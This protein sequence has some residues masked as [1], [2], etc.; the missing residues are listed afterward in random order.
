MKEL[1]I[2]IVLYKTPLKHIKRCL[3]CFLPYKEIADIYL[4]DISP[5]RNLEKIKTLYEG[6]KYIFAN[7]NKGYARGHNKALHMAS[8]NKYKYHLLLNADCYFCGEII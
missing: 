4:I 3:S 7:S 5:N 6:C 1:S 2:S 8:Q